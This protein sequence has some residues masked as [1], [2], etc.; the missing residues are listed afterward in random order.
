MNARLSK[1]DKENK[2]AKIFAKIITEVVISICKPIRS[3]RS[4][5]SKGS[6]SKKCQKETENMVSS[7]LKSM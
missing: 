4:L 2:K 7:F 1:L 6:L 5:L 3:P